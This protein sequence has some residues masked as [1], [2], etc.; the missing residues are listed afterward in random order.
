MMTNT[1]KL[2]E[3]DILSRLCQGE[4][5]ETI[6]NATDVSYATV[7]RVRREYESESCAQNVNDDKVTE[8]TDNV[9][10]IKCA[11][12]TMTNDKLVDD[13]F[14]GSMSNV[15]ECLEGAALTV[16]SRISQ[17]AA[18][19]KELNA[20]DISDLA[21]A[22]AKLKVAFSVSSSDSQGSGLSQFVSLMKG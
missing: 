19:S 6:S 3:A 13:V 16:L 9:G 2:V 4:T 5:A 12:S 21:A 8:L 17:M 20:H 10:T 14:K 22:T 11:V 18:Y 15:N 1:K 7:I